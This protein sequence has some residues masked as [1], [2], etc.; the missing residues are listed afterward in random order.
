VS[1]IDENTSQGPQ[2]T[3]EEMRAYLQEL[4][5]TPVAQVLTEVLSVLLNAAQVKLGR[6]D[7]RLVLDTVALLNDTTAAALPE[8]IVT[9]VRGVLAQL[10][11]AQVEAEKQRDPNEPNDLQAPVA[12]TPPAGNDAQSAASRLWTPS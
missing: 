12:V 10:R 7:G 9:Q 2:P 5:D 8:E 11:I 1:D 3:E 4:R 6:N